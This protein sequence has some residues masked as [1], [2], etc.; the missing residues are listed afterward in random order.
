MDPALDEI[1]TFLNKSRVRATYGAVAQIL[2]VVPRSMGAR[3]GRHNI[4]D[5]Q[6]PRRALD[7]LE[8]GIAA[9]RD[10]VLDD[11]V[12]V[13]AHELHRGRS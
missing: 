13:H 6:P 8:T 9:D 2:G 3:L 5:V 4:E 10:V 11:R 1:I 7:D 12:D